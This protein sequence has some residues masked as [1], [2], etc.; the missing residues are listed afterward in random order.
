[1]QFARDEPPRLANIDLASEIDRGLRLARPELD[2][3][4]VTVEVESESSCPVRADAQRL[5]Q[6]VLNLVL[7]AAQAMPGGGTLR[8]RTSRD[9]REARVVFQD[10]GPGLDPAVRERIFEPFVTTKE[11]GSGLGLAVARRIVEEHGGTISAGDA[12]GGGAAIEIRL[13]LAAGS[14]PPSTSSD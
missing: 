7:N 10:T 1:L 8:V 12:P 9:G 14:D 3:A 2:P 13:P 4:R 11:K 5:Q 6:V